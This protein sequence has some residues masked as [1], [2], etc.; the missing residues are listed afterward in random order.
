MT[1]CVLV[2][3]DLLIN[4]LSLCHPSKNDL[5]SMYDVLFKR[6]FNPA[7]IKTLSNNKKLIEML[8]FDGN[9]HA[10]RVTYLL[11]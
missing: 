4:I 3:K 6:H 9:Q 11:K 5:V 7:S 1:V 8:A 2:L 10:S